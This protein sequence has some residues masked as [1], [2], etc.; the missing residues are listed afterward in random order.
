MARSPAPFP[1]LCSISRYTPSHVPLH[2]AML[3]SSPFSVIIVTVVTHHRNDRSYCIVV[4]LIQHVL[5]KTAMYFV[6]HAGEVDA[7]ILC[8]EE[9][10]LHDLGSALWYGGSNR[11]R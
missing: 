8:A 4:S 10:I 3:L 9:R 6:H 5:E 7:F 11:N 2:L 1:S